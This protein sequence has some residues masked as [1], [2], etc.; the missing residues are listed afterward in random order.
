MDNVRDGDRGPSQ[1][2]LDRAPDTGYLGIRNRQAASLDARKREMMGPI[3]EGLRLLK[4]ELAAPP[5]FE[6]AKRAGGVLVML[7]PYLRAVLSYERDVRTG[8][9]HIF[10]A[11][12]FPPELGLCGGEYSDP[13]EALRDIVRAICFSVS[14]AERR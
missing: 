10:L 7:R 6:L 12:E 14:E 9:D 5:T 13:D 3:V 11:G 2:Q 1:A 8:E 4:K